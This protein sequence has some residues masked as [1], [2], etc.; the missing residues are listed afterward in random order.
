M[1]DQQDISALG[2]SPP[3]A[4][5][6]PC[7]AAPRSASA[8]TR[9]PRGVVMTFLLL[10]SFG[11]G[12][13]LS[14]LGPTVPA[15]AARL[16]VPEA[17][18]GIL[19][20]ANF[21]VATVATAASGTLLNRLGVRSLIPA[22]LVAMALGLGVEGTAATLPLVVLGALLA[23][24][25]TGI[26]NVSVNAAA[27][28]LYSARRDAVLTWLNVTFGV[29]A[30]CTPLAAGLSL[31]R[32]GGY[33][34]VYL[35]GAAIL[36][37]PI[38]PLLRGLPSSTPRAASA[39]SGRTTLLRLLRDANLR[40][41][42]ALA[43]V[44]LGAEIGFGGWVITIVAAMTHLPPAHLAPAASAFWICLAAG[45]APTVLLLHRG[46]RPRHLIV[47]GA[48]AA[49]AESGLLLAVGG[50]APLAIACCALIGLSFAPILPLATAL[51]TA[52]GAA[53]GSDAARL[54]AIFTIGQIGGAILP[55]VQG[56]LLGA[57]PGPA[58]GLTAACA[59]TMAAL[60]A[61]VRSPAPAH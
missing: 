45:G 59:L 49:A 17:A 8:L 61:A 14:I 51:A 12:V 13:V 56:A 4:G 27:V 28:R 43:A 52:Q 9:L 47:L 10:I 5:G 42:V 25:G 39:P 33:T 48:L 50:S 41:L 2:G 44:Y 16:G 26:I 57:G 7:P 6:L 1:A 36:L 29:G 20:T 46:M 32:L 40:L 30:F 54:A 60:A 35:A 22:G 18:L 37:V 58:L 21:L 23:G 19:F 38:A 11:T 24:S 55:A 34:P 31:T 15:I 53:D 3:S